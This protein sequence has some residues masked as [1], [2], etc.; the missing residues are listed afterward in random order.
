MA[1]SGRSK[2]PEP[3]LARVD[4]LGLLPG[5]E[6]RAGERLKGH[7]AYTVFAAHG[8]DLPTLHAGLQRG[9]LWVVEVA[10]TVA[11]YLLAGQLDSAFHVLQMDVD[12]AHARQGLGRALLR[13]ALAVAHADGF[14][15][16]VLTTLLD[17]PWNAAFYTSEGFDVVQPGQWGAGL[18]AV[19][20]EEA[21]LGFPMH[22]RV[23]MRRAL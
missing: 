23:A 14:A 9:Q 13:N 3:R 17:V 22:L 8:L 21:A 7:P 10:G 2:S 1:G 15:S 12:P 4:D 11:G 18:Q 16:A 6:R 20:A 19:M 5:I